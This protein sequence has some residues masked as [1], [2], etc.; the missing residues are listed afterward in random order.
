VFRFVSL[1]P[2]SDGGHAPVTLIYGDVVPG[3]R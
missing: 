1:S 3:G 2:R